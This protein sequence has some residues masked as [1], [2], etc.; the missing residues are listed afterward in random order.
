MACVGCCGGV[1]I[2]MWGP[3]KRIKWSVRRWHDLSEELVRSPWKSPPI[4]IMWFGKVRV[5]VLSDMHASACS[6]RSCGR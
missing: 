3:L 6:A 2:G 5:S 4:I 1:I